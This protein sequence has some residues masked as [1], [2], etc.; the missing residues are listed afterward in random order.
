MK[1]GCEALS[2]GPGALL[3]RSLRDWNCHSNDS[4]SHW[5]SWDLKEVERWRKFKDSNRTIGEIDSQPLTIWPVFPNL[6]VSDFS[7]F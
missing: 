1:G 4:E 2:P 3:S 7:F 6:I 5:C